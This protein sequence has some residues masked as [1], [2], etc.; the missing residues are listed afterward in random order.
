MLR[1]KSE[2][3]I[4]A[5]AL[6]NLAST[7]TTTTIREAHSEYYGEL[8]RSM[9]GGGGGG[10]GSDG[11]SGGEGRGGGGEGSGGW[12]RP[13]EKRVTS[14][15]A[16]LSGDERG[17]GPDDGEHNSDEALQVAILAIA[18]SPASVSLVRDLMA[19]TVAHKKDLDVAIKKAKAKDKLKAKQLLEEGKVSR[20]P[21]MQVTC[22]HAQSYLVI[23][24]TRLI[25]PHPRSTFHLCQPADSSAHHQPT[26][27]Q[28][29]NPP[30]TLRSI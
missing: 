17:N 21:D 12:V 25:V 1:R 22:S 15:G 23:I 10:G 4:I 9:G 7:V 24:S 13:G 18:D 6:T 19:D 2:S 16:L 14:L 5:E 30:R 20:A 27:K 26:I 11:G 3:L 8:N 29:R 28:S